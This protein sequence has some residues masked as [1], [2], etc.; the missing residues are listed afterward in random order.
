MSL[1]PAYT[2]REG[3]VADLPLYRETIY[4]ALMWNPSRVLP[5]LDHMMVHPEII[6]YHK[7]WG[8]PGDI[9]VVAELAATPIGAAF[10]RLFSID[11]HGDGFVDAATPELTIAVADGHR[12]RG[13]GGALLDALESRARAAAIAQLSLSVEAENPAHHLHER[14]GYKI[15]ANDYRGLLMLKELRAR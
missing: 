12:G 7:A 1:D 8:R 4:R 6:R 15:V 10:Y 5:P 11:D 2:L 14:A 9:A 13:L 3:G